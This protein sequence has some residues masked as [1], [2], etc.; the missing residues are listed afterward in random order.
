MP[1]LLRLGLAGCYIGHGAFGVITKAGWLPYFAVVGIGEPL[2]WRMM[3]WI[4]WMDI[5]MGI[6][7]LVWP[8]RAL[9]LWATI[10]T[11]WTALL[12]P[13]AGEPAWEFF[14]RA[15]NYGVPLALLVMARLRRPWFARLSARWPGVASAAGLQPEQ[16]LKITTATLLAGHA[17]CGL[18]SKPLLGH[19]YSA[20]GAPATG[21]MVQSVGVFEFCLAGWVLVRPTTG[22]LI[23]V[24][25]W[26][27]ASEAL[28][29]LSGAPAWEFVERCGSYAA[30]LAL[31]L[32]LARHH[33]RPK[34]PALASTG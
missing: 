17:G 32:L 11:A 23:G 10:W 12:R 9:F 26:K 24:C 20:L 16:V 3:P 14:E 25:I 27:L 6:L 8:C 18:L 15:G 28:F 2:A 13:L 34:I 22:L 1:W 19:L 29:P 21:A 31:A 7:A 4:G 33:Q 5:S 30:P